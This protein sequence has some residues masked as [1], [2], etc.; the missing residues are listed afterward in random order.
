[1][2][3]AL[4]HHRSVRQPFDEAVERCNSTSEQALPQTVCI[5]VVE[6]IKLAVNGVRGNRGIVDFDKQLSQRQR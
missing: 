1:M 5:V 2:Q 3:I 6:G 4:N